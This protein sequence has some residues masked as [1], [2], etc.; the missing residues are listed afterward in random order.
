MVRCPDPLSLDGSYAQSPLRPV[1]TLYDG[2][3]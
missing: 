1:V 2:L 3:G